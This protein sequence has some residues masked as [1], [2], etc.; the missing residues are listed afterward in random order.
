VMMYPYPY[1]M[2]L[3]EDTELFR[4]IMNQLGPS[5]FGGARHACTYPDRQGICCHTLHPGATSTSWAQYLLGEDEIEDL[6]VADLA[7]WQDYRKLFPVNGKVSE[8]IGQSGRPRRK[9]IVWSNSDQVEL[10]ISP[11]AK[12]RT[13][14]EKLAKKTGAASAAEMELHSSRPAPGRKPIPDRQR[15]EA[16]IEEVWVHPPF[17]TDRELRLRELTKAGAPALSYDRFCEFC[18]RLLSAFS[19]ESFQVKIHEAYRES[20]EKPIEFM[21]KKQAICLPIQIPVLKEFG[22]EPSKRGLQHSTSLWTLVT[23]DDTVDTGLLKNVGLALYMATDPAIQAQWQERERRD[24]ASNDSLTH[25]RSQREAE[26][27]DA[28]G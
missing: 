1:D 9:L 6:D 24:M 5:I 20:S 27:S 3:G 23:Q 22:F 10:K 18:M 2:N 15:L 28:D 11:L 4:R 16:Q 8:Y 14:K 21:R 7:C 25:G 12:C 17:L 19:E 26:R 13:A